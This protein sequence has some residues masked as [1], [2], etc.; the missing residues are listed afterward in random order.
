[1][2]LNEVTVVIAVVLAILCGIILLLIDWFHH[3]IRIHESLIAGISISYFFLVVLPE[4]SEGIPAYPL[5]LTNFEYLFVLLGFVI[6][7]VSEKLILQKAENNSQK[8]MRELVQMEKTLEIVE[9]NMTDLISIELEKENHD[10]AVLKELAD[11]TVQLHSQEKSIAKEITEQKAKITHHMNKDLNEIRW[12]TQFIYHFLI[13]VLLISLLLIDII[14]GL[15]FF[16]FAGF[17][18]LITNRTKKMVIFSDLDIEVELHEA[19]MKWRMILSGAALFG[20][21]FGF[22]LDL[23]I[24]MN[25]EIIYLIFS[26]VSGVILYTIIRKEFPE[27]EKGKPILF[28]LGVIGFILFVLVFNLIEHRLL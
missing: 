27:K 13:G 14:S 28:L 7:H 10:E 12:I 3:L 21:L 24:P 8:R 1:M 9:H 5:H 18:A 17:M 6:V 22:F 20:V 4:I 26:F 19:A 15:L 2:L 11:T 23:V 16:L 25:L